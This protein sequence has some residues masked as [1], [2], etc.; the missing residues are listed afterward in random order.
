MRQREI[1]VLSTWCQQ[2]ISCSCF[3]SAVKTVSPS[4]PSPATFQS[5]LTHTKWIIHCLIT[6]RVSMKLFCPNRKI[7]C[8][9]LVVY[10]NHPVS[11]IP[12]NA[13]MMRAH[14][15][16]SFNRKQPSAP[17]DR[18][19]SGI[20]LPISALRWKLHELFT[21]GFELDSS[22]CVLVI[23]SACEGTPIACR[24]LHGNNTD[25]CDHRDLTW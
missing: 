11:I 17:L 8:S 6:L 20:N 12:K 18:W 22:W 14:C 24:F 2:P 16:L 15:A 10:L 4:H 3:V 9:C 23:D 21:Q 13:T 25:M 19:P 7:G 5:V 1:W